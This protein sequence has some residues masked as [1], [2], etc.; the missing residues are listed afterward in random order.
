M[1]L[2]SSSSGWADALRSI[3]RRALYVGAVGAAIFGF[4]ALTHGK[5]LGASGTAVAYAESIHHSVSPIALG[6]V[7]AL[8][9]TVGQKVKAGE[10]LAVM[11][12]RDL[13]AAR[14]KAL[15]QLSQYE[16][17]V[18]AS[19]QDQEFQVTRSELWVLKARAD[20]HGDRARYAEITERMN[21][22][23]GL[24]DRQ[25]IP[26]SQAEQARE[27]MSEL[28]A[29]IE[30]FDQAKTRGQAGLGQSG[31]GNHNHGHAVDVHV[32]PLRRAVL[33]QQAAIRQLDVQIEQLTL[34]S[35]VDGIVSTLSHRP[36]EIIGAGVEVLSVVSARPGVVIAELPEGMATRVHPGQSVNIHTKDLF[37]RSLRGH[38]LELAPE[39]DEMIPRARPSPSIAAWGRR[40]TI[41][42]EGGADVLPGQ[43]VNVALD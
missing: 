16:A 10:T 23:N 3:P 33:V 6:R 28:Q 37:S 22:L 42:L 34:K 1:F 21:R 19:S 5:G 40:A 9:V 25:M 41:Q 39:V 38:V 11:D 20:E 26:A 29:R 27:E 36:G 24:L 7:E 17:A 13:A 43:A 30:T 14:D 35:P 32:E 15:A 4:A 12:G 2:L 18:A 31:A 8:L